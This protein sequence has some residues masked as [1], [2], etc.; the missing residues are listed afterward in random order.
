MI[1]KIK[2]GLHCADTIPVIL[3]KLIYNATYI[4]DLTGFEETLISLTQTYFPSRFWKYD[5]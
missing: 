2:L 3:Y 5:I 1:I 4:G